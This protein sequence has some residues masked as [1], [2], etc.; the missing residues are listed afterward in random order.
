MDRVGGYVCVSITEANVDHDQ[1]VDVVQMI[2]NLRCSEL[3]IDTS[4][5][6]VARC[7]TD[8]FVGNMARDMELTICPTELELC[9][10]SFSLLE[11]STLWTHT[12]CVQV[13]IV[14][15]GVG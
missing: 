11:H 7:P 5:N 13:D 3:A 6:K 12:F 10:V 1:I 15:F 8:D 9:T 2:S 4:N 14:A